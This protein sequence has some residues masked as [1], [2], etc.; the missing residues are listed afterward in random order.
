MALIFHGLMLSVILIENALQVLG[1]N[2]NVSYQIY[3]QSKTWEEAKIDCETKNGSLAEFTSNEQVVNLFN[4]P[5]FNRCYHLWINIYFLQQT[6]LVWLSNNETVNL[7]HDAVSK[8]YTALCGNIYFDFGQSKFIV[9]VLSCAE[10]H[11]Y[12]CMTLPDVTTTTTSTTEEPTTT[13]TT[14]TEEPT[15]TTTSTTEA[16]TTATTSTTEAPTTA[17]T[18]TTE[19]PTTATTSTTEAP[20]TAT[21]STTEAPTTATTSTTEAPTT[22]T[23]ST[24][25]APAT[26]TT[27]PAATMSTINNTNTQIGN[28]PET[29]TQSSGMTFKALSILLPL[30]LVI[31]FIEIST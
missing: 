24:T 10:N 8:S 26:T 6:E 29:T 13:T 20:T 7:F 19:A 22:A 27:T 4:S 3:F 25:E 14:T 11:Y 2:G 28:T 21:T 17:T 18:S 16:P 12:M 15:T 9:Q 30:H 31:C 5:D 23:T 1:Q